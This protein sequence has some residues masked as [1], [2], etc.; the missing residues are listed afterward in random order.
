MTMTIRHLSLPVCAALLCACGTKHIADL[1]TQ[2]L[3]SSED[4]GGAEAEDDG[5]GQTVTSAGADDDGGSSSEG[6]EAVECEPDPNAV[7]GPTPLETLVASVVPAPPV[8]GGALPLSNGYDCTITELEWMGEGL[9]R[10]ILD[11]GL[12]FP[13]DASTAL[14]AATF[15]KLALDQ[16]VHVQF[17]TEEA[18]N[19]NAFTLSND[20]GDPLVIAMWGTTVDPIPGVDVFAP[21]A[22]SANEDECLA[23]CDVV[24]DRCYSPDRQ[25]LTF[26]ADGNDIA[27]VWSQGDAS[28]TVDGHDYLIEAI[29]FGAEKVNP[30]SWWCSMPGYASY[31]FRIADVTP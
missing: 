9:T 22:V 10:I 13:T 30:D 25:S 31:S 24:D 19:G 6:G 20:D 1:E 12:E 27:T 18:G 26:S 3:A 11:C 2:E 23:P 15:A 17:S 7:C 4:D 21:F 29:A 5:P 28:V 14:P 8:S 16:D